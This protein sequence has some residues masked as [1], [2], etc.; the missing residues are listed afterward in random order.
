MTHA[1]AKTGAGPT[2]MV[3]IERMVYAEKLQLPR[4]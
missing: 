4:R 2:M 1:A 3:A